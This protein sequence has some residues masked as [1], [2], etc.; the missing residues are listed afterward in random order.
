[1]KLRGLEVIDIKSRNGQ[2]VMLTAS[3]L[4]DKTLVLVEVADG[5]E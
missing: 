1:M 3:K 4:L 2:P 5:R